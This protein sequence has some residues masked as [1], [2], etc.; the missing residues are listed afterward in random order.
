M[1]ST[2]GRQRTASGDKRG[3]QEFD[4][5]S[6]LKKLLRKGFKLFPP[7]TEC[8]KAA[9]EGYWGTNVNGNAQ[10]RVRFTCAVCGRKFNEYTTINRVK[11]KNI[12]IDHKTPISSADGIADFIAK[13]FCSLSNLQ[14]LCSYRLSRIAEFG[15]V[16]SCHT[17]KTRAEAA[18]RKEARDHAKLP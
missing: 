10:W 4:L 6:F 14:V 17:Q 5:D 1:A 13:L 15:G 11:Y 2:E 3:V 7:Y 9:K 12:E 16:P 18:A 8:L